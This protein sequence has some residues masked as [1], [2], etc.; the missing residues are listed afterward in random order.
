MVCLYRYLPQG[1]TRQALHEED[2]D[3]RGRTAQR[4]CPTLLRGA[5]RDQYRKCVQSPVRAGKYSLKITLDLY[6]SEKTHRTEI[7][8][9]DPK[10][11]KIGEEYWL[12]ESIFLPADWGVSDTNEIVT[13]FH[14]WNSRGLGPPFS[15]KVSGND[16]KI[17]N[18]WDPTYE[19][20][21]PSPTLQ[22]KTWNLGPVA[23][24]KWTDWVF[25]IKLSYQ[26]DGVLEVWKNGELVVQRK[27]PN[28]YN[29][30]YGPY[31]KFGIYKWDWGNKNVTRRVLYFDEIRI[32]KGAIGYEFVAPT[33][34]SL[35]SSSNLSGLDLKV[36]PQ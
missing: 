25:H 23:R 30:E 18:K 35:S 4:S 20:R 2:A 3:H 6:E 5:W 15:L 12:G 16:W 17:Q 10:E 33:H 7:R 21:K 8:F 24:G 13:Q 27:G 11:F 14:A 22:A 26:A 29:A 31:L 19:S 36:L 9:D 34:S 1:G 28:T 32:A